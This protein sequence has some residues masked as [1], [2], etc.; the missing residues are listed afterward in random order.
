MPQQVP[1]QHPTAYRNDSLG[2][3]DNPDCDY[4][5]VGGKRFYTAKGYAVISKTKETS[6]PFY[7]SEYRPAGLETWKPERMKLPA[8]ATIVSSDLIIEHGAADT[9]ISGGADTLHAHYEAGVQDPR[10]TVSV[11][12]VS[13]GTGA[14][15]LQYEQGAY[16]PLEPYDLF[17]MGS[18]LPVNVGTAPVDFTLYSSSTNGVKLHPDSKHDE[19]RVGCAVQ[20]YLPDSPPSHA[21]IVYV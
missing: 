20:F 12:A 11:P 10:V 17:A 13:A 16:A 3:V 8:N 14:S 5:L 18:D 21:E 19:I 9:L 7:C 15:F 6:L 4:L 1:G 2:G